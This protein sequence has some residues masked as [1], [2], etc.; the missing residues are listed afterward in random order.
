MVCI[1]EAVGDLRGAGPPDLVYL[2][3]PTTGRRDGPGLARPRHGREAW[4][5]P[6]GF[7]GPLGDQALYGRPLPEGVETAE[8]LSPTASSTRSSRPRNRRI[9]GR[10][11]N[12]PDGCERRRAPVAAP[13]RCGAGRRQLGL[14][15]SVA[16]TGPAGRTP[17]LRYGALDVVPLKGTGAGRGRSGAA[18][19]AGALWRG[20]V[21][22][23]GPGPARA[24][25]DDPLG[26][27]ALREARRG[28]RL[29]SELGLPLVTGIDTQGAALSADAENGGLAGDIARPLADLVTL[30]RPTRA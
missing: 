28:M 13:A 9:L 15:V 12:D 30:E 18:D 20:A 19:R 29:A 27:G 7:L 24:D 22:L 11:L 21:R 2:R 26:P 4:S 5:A 16:M 1:S 25:P 10:A 14:R 23:P 17:L 6:A 8:N 3:D